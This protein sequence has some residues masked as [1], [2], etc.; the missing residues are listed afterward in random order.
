MILLLISH[1]ALQPPVLTLG[2]SGSASATPP[3]AGYPQLGGLGPTIPQGSRVFTI[4]S[5]LLCVCST[6]FFPALRLSQARDFDHSRWGAAAATPGRSFS[7]ELSQLGD[8][9]SSSSSSALAAGLTWS[10]HQRLEE[11]RRGQFSFVFDLHQQPV[12]ARSVPARSLSQGSPLF[13]SKG[14]RS[15]SRLGPQQA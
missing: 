14:A 11:A 6:C 1:L 15:A 5:L 10:S 12:S 9:G 2:G 13:T 4:M 7:A 3:R 8:L